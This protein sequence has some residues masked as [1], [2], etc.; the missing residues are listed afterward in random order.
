MQQFM[1][2]PEEAASL[3]LRRLYSDCGYSFYRMSRFEE[4]DFYADK[5]DFLMS[6][7][8]L[9]FTD[10]DGR[11]MALRPDVTLS[12]IK[13][14]RNDGGVQ[15]FFYDEKVYR[16][17]RNSASFHEIAQAGVECMGALTKKDIDEVTGL[18]VESLKILAKGR[19][20]VL[21]VADAGKIS[22]LLNGNREQ[23]AILRCLA[24]KN[25]HGLK[26]LNA[27]EEIIRLAGS[28]EEIGECI[29]VDY[30]AVGSLS[31]YNGI[32]FKGY[33]EGTSECI[34]SGGQ[35]DNLMAA[36]GHE[37][38]KAIGFAVN[39]ELAGGIEHA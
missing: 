7:A 15:K 10:A 2:R 17:P 38:A 21:D 27:P 26:S 1:L 36:M 29:R 37:G 32:V 28:S 30:S 35:Y 13:H 31:Y 24:E 12:I 39:L 34:L 25:I 11:L 18:A 3:P 8:V 5:K 14:W 4:Y 16:V 22:A 6:N 33:I 9:T 20:Y 23:N 19:R